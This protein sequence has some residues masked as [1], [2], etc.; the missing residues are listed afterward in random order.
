MSIKEN[1]LNRVNRIAE[2]HFL[3][4]PVLISALKSH[5][6]TAEGREFFLNSE[7]YHEY[8]TKTLSDKFYDM[9]A[10]IRLGSEIE[11]CLRDYYVAKKGYKNLSKLRADKK[12]KRG[13][14]QRILPWQTGANDAMSLFANE[15]GYDLNTNTHF[16]IVQELMLLRHLYAHNTG[17]IDDQ[18]I[19]DYINITGEDVTAIPA[20][21]GGSYPDEDVYFFKPLSRL[22]EF[23]EGSKRS[24]REFP[25]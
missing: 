24:F 14:C 12:Y 11:V 1:I 22:N 23:I 15:L 2:T 6:I 16:K 5:I 9:G 8:W 10:L 13:I 21:G 3:L 17:I 18:F 25:D 7:S 19:Q 4:R 20:L